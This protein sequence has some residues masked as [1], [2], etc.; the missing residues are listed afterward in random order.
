[1]DPLMLAVTTSGSS[2]GTGVVPMARRTRSP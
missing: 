2:S 1:M